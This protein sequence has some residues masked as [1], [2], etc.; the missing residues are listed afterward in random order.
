MVKVKC[1]CV[2][3]YCEANTKWWNQVDQCFLPFT[4]C[5]YSFKNVFTMRSLKTKWMHQREWARIVLGQCLPC[6][7]WTVFFHD[8]TNNQRNRK[9]FLSLTNFISVKK[10]HSG[11]KE[12]KKKKFSNWI[13]RTKPMKFSQNQTSRK[14]WI[15][16]IG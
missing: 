7:D 9:L 15:K 11:K 14:K 4:I 1:A 5:G 12:F 8:Y 16:L 13:Y 3:K 6:S 2:A 10:K